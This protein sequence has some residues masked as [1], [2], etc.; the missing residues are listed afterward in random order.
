MFRFTPVFLK[1]HL[2]FFLL[3]VWHYWKKI[4]QNIGR[5]H[6]VRGRKLSV[7]VCCVQIAVQLSVLIGKIARID[8]PRSWPQLIPVLLSAIHV[9]DPLCQQRALQTLLSVVKSLA[10]RRLPADRRVFEDVRVLSTCLQYEHNLWMVVICW[11]SSDSYLHIF[12]WIICH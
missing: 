11:H 4:C 2:V 5:F 6:E 10:S 1:C 8:C 3:D 7:K 9:T 12:G